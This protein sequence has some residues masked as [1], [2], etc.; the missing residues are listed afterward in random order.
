M[1][2]WKKGDVGICI[3]AGEIGPGKGLSPPLRLK[4]EYIIQD[5]FLCR[6]GELALDVGLSSPLHSNG[7][8]CDCRIVLPYSDVHWC[9]AVRFVKKKSKEET[10]EAIAEAVANEDYELADTLRKGLN[11]E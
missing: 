1:D 2:E 6:C 4:A 3:N 10:E 8:F 9:A 5:V 7:T 11:G